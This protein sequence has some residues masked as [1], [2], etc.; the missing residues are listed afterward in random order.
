[1]RSITQSP[2]WPSCPT[3]FNMARYVL[4]P[5]ARLPGKTAL[6][7]IGGAQ[8][9]SWSF[10]EIETTV[11][12]MATGFLELGAQPGDRILLRLG[13]SPETPLAYLAAIAGD[14][15]PIPASAMLTEPEIARIIAETTPRLVLRDETLPC[16]DHPHMVSLQGLQDM[17][18]LPLADYSIGDPN[19][20]AYIV[21]TS[22]TSGKPRGVVHAHRAIWARQMMHKAWY[23]LTPEDRMMHAGAFNWTYTMGT[24][25]MDPWSLGATALIPAPGCAPE[26]LLSLIDLHKPTLFAAAPGVIRKATKDGQKLTSNSL[27]HGLSAGEK[28]SPRITQAWKNA[29][30]TELYEAYGMSEC[31]TF[32]SACPQYPASEGTTGRPQKG[33]KIALL[34]ET[35]APVPIGQSGVISVHCSDPG[36]MLGY[37]GEAP[38][39]SEWFSTGDLGIM[40]SSGEITYLGRDDDMMNAGGYRVSPLEVE[41]A[42][43]QMSDIQA[44]AVTSLEVKPDV[45][46][47]AAFYTAPKPLDTGHLSSFAQERLAAYKCPRLFIHVTELPTGPNGKLQR[48]ALPALWRS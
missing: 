45:H 30:G 1:M 23:D 40:H 46:Q 9:R 24:G 26:T 43:A 11:R 39:T 14:L 16:P 21:Y 36:L 31:S 4:E 27:R 6:E 28:L 34:D 10:A 20:P 17:G 29:T 38:N 15:I 3:P 42:L 2:P 35:G 41:A 37:L 32:I 33:R 19:R 25:L 8:P 22:G 13:N 47:I 48:R 7:I 5:A 18:S 44:I 12:A